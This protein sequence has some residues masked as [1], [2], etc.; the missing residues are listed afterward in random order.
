MGLAAPAGIAA[1]VDVVGHGEV[2]SSCALYSAPPHERFMVKPNLDLK[3][4]YVKL[5][6]EI[7]YLARQMLF[8]EIEN[9]STA[10]LD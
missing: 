7:I 6:I 5:Q 2:L 8:I 10:K 1:G 3:L 4:I 9:K